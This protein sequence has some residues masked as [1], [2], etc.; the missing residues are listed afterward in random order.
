MILAIYLYFY[1]ISL[2]LN[3]ALSGYPD[4]IVQQNGPIQWPQTDSHSKLFFRT[5]YL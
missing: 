1:E 2:K 5:T 3:L 4:Q